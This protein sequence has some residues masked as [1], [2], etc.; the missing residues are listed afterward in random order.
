MMFCGNGGHLSLQ[1]ED[2]VGFFRSTR[3][4]CFY[5][6][7]GAPDM[8]CKSNKDPSLL[9][10]FV[11]LRRKPLTDW[12]NSIKFRPS[13]AVGTER[14]EENFTRSSVASPEPSHR[15]D[16]P[17]QGRAKDHVAVVCLGLGPLGQHAGDRNAEGGNQG[18]RHQQD[19][20]LVV[21]SVEQAVVARHHLVPAMSMSTMLM[22]RVGADW[23]PT[24]PIF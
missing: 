12:Q 6:E 21:E 15:L 4:P 22:G 13:V 14:T 11:G 3:T 5:F 17:V 24:S 20:H 8:Y 9:P 23:V 1:T 2:Y 18:R 16:C 19:D 10:V 7:H